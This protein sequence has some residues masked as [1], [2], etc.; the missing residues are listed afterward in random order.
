MEQYLEYTKN[1]YLVT[2][3]QTDFSCFGTKPL[4]KL[5]TWPGFC[6]SQVELAYLVNKIGDERGCFNV[7]EAV[8]VVSQGGECVVQVVEGSEED[9]RVGLEKPERRPLQNL[10]SMFQNFSSSSTK[11]T[12]NKL[13]C[14]SLANLFG[15]V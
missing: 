11:L 9:R 8:G 13:E 3:F 2:I 5:K 7:V 15:L 14:L 1:C 6:Q 12:D 10:A 4:K